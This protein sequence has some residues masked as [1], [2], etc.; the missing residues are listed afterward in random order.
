MSLFR[1]IYF[2][3]K[4]L[5]RD[6]DILFKHPTRTASWKDLKYH[7][8]K[9][10]DTIIFHPWYCLKRGIRNIFVWFPIIWGNNCWDYSFL[11][12]LMN[13]QM[14]EM[15]D[16]F[17]SDNTHIINAKRYGRQIRWTRKLMDMWREEYYTMKSMDEYHR[18]YPKQNRWNFEPHTTDGY[19]IVTSYINGNKKS[20]EE[21]EVFGRLMDEGRE[22]DEKVFKLFIKN[23]SNL[24]GWWD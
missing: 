5:F 18:L 7:W 2:D 13:K 24:R 3:T 14:K 16:F 15:E 20:D 10:W 22:K 11:C 4:Y 8:L 9:L 1:N 19:G 17:Y 12:N 6:I 23:L 21:K